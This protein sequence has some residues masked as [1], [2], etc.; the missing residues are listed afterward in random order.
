M[1][2]CARVKKL[3]V[4]VDES[5]G[6]LI[7]VR[8]AGRLAFEKMIDSNHAIHETH[9]KRIYF[10]ADDYLTTGALAALSYAGLKVPEDVR[11][12][13]FANAGLGPDYHRPLSRMEFDSTKAGVTVADV[14]LGFLKTGEFPSGVAVGPKWID[15]ETMGEDE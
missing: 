11:L 10:I 15:G 7:G 9:E 13:T 12:V 4:P 5:E 2:R 6:R 3:K 8:R 14:I 1:R